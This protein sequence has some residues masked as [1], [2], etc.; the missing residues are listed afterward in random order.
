MLKMHKFI[1]KVTE[2]SQIVQDLI[3]PQFQ[4]NFKDGN[5]N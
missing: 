4:Q 1:V 5:R 3:E 2:M